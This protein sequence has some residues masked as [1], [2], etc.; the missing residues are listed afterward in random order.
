M[1]RREERFFDTVY[2]DGQPEFVWGLATRQQTRSAENG[3]LTSARTLDL[4]VC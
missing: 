1:T 3:V 4:R 2:V